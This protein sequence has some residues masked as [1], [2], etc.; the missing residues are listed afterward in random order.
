MRN[1]EW[2]MR[3]ENGEWRKWFGEWGMDSEVANIGNGVK[4][5]GK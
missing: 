2:R 1:E 3:K 5:R 4:D